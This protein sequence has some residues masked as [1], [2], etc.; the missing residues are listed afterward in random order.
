MGKLELSHLWLLP[1]TAALITEVRQ[2]SSL[3]PSLSLPLSLSRSVSLSLSLSPLSPLY[4]SHSSLWSMPVACAVGDGV[5][6][7]V[8]VSVQLRLWTC[9]HVYCVLVQWACVFVC[10]CIPDWPCFDLPCSVVF[11][12]KSCVWQR[13]VLKQQGPSADKTGV[14]GATGSSVKLHSSTV[15]VTGLC[16]S[17][18]PKKKPLYPDQTLFDWPDY[19]SE[20]N[21]HH[22]RNGLEIFWQFCLLE[23]VRK[24][25]GVARKPLLGPQ[26]FLTLVMWWHLSHF[27]N[28]GRKMCL[29]LNKYKKQ[30]LICGWLCNVKLA[31]KD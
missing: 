25:K 31:V 22:L 10:V 2:P 18:Y 21:F 4:L 6:G 23:K 26:K 16:K 9:Y 19:L 8:F 17:L 28:R 27:L 11:E 3:S 29:K 20:G 24:G 12:L 14:P 7:C 13:L 15:T 5:F 1:H 30:L